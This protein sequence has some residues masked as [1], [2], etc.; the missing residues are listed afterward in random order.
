MRIHRREKSR[1]VHQDLLSALQWRQKMKSYRAGGETMRLNLKSRERVIKPRSWAP[2]DTISLRQKDKS[3]RS[4]TQP[5][6]IV[7]TMYFFYY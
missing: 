7:Y 2:R 3:L 6:A 4:V 1:V 5:R